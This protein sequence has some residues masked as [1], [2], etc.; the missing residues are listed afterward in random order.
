MKTFKVL[1]NIAKHLQ[2]IDSDRRDRTITKKEFEAILNGPNSKKVFSALCSKDVH[3]N[4]QE[5]KNDFI[6][7]QEN[8]GLTW[9][10]RPGHGGPISLESVTLP[11]EIGKELAKKLRSENVKNGSFIDYIQNNLSNLISY[12]ENDITLINYSEAREAFKEYISN[13]KSYKF[14][15][16]RSSVQ[17]ELTKEIFTF[18]AN[19]KSHA[20]LELGALIENKLKHYLSL[21]LLHHSQSGRSAGKFRN[22]DFVG[23]KIQRSIEKDEFLMYSFELKPSNSINSI[24]QAIS[25][26]VNYHYLSNYTYII[27]P[28]FDVQSFY[29]HERFQ[30]FLEMCK[31]NKLGVLS[32]VIDPNTNQV[33]D[34]SEVLQAPKTEIENYNKLIELVRESE[35][36]SCPICKRI[37]N[38]ESRKR[39][40]WLVN[41]NEDEE[42]MKK[43]LEKNFMS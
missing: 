35:W 34:I 38:K 8:N 36:E 2:L 22:I 20:E 6:F 26:A 19:R 24:S 41:V 11:V 14:I 30:D 29:D 7:F 28:F 5:F 31:K 32:I 27:I 23:F 16:G 39:C 15:P 12:L 3:E 37:V 18:K 4:W 17:F 13:N 33:S 9:M 25:Q 42:C 21:D 43:L 10:A 1:E 40:G